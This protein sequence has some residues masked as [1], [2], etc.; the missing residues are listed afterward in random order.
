MP[1][2]DEGSDEDGEG[3]KP[4][5]IEEFT[6]K[7]NEKVDMKKTQSTLKFGKKSYPSKYGRRK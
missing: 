6:Q 5:T 7:A 4:L 2:F 3:E 1:S